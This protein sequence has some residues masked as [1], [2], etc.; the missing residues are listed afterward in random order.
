MPPVSCR[1][2][3]DH[4]GAR[5]Q[6]ASSTLMNSSQSPGLG[7][8]QIVV[9]LSAR[10]ARPSDRGEVLIHG[11]ATAR[12]GLRM[13]AP[14]PGCR[15][16]ASCFSST[17]CCRNSSILDNV[18]LPIV[19]SARVPPK[20]CGSAPWRSCRR[21][22]SLT[23]CTSGRTSCRVGSASASQSHARS[24]TIRRSYSPTSRPDCSIC[25][26]SEQVFQLLRDLVDKQGKTVLAVT[27]DLEMALRMDRRI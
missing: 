12:Y 3:A 26:R 8:R 14:R 1:R 10:P 23:T 21:W 13:S 22:G 27:H 6:C 11:K 9:A 18:M 4:A 2:G 20:R 16:W 24:P 5:R 17:S 15:S 7:L 19:R 25:T